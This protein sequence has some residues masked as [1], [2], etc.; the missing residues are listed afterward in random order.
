VT[1]RT[2]TNVLLRQRLRAAYSRTL[3]RKRRRAPKERLLKQRW[4]FT[5]NVWMRC[6]C[7]GRNARRDSEIRGSPPPGPAHRITP[8]AHHPPGFIEPCLPTNGHAVPTGPQWAYEIKHDGFRFVCWP[9]HPAI[10]AAPCRPAP[11]PCIRRTSQASSRH[12]GRLSASR[13]RHARPLHVG[14]PL[15]ARSMR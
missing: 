3:P 8:P 2:R 9:P 7:S 10:T 13:A 15:R 11:G 12:A 6:V 14:V 1:T 4:Q 5:S